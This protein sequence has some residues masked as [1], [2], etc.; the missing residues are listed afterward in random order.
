MKLRTLIIFISLSVLFVIAACSQ[1]SVP[2]KNVIAAD[3]KGTV[4]LSDSTMTE[5]ISHLMQF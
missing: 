3:H 2:T 5:R 1:K 4:P